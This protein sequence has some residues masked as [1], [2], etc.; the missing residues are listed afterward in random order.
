MPK[1]GRDLRGSTRIMIIVIV[2]K[3]TGKEEEERKKERKTAQRCARACI[4][5][6]AVDI[7]RPSTGRGR[8]PST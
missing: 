5:P 6:R 8:R 4:A 3:E 7:H 1:A 2:V